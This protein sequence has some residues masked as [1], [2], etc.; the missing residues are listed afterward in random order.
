MAG[1]VA[2]MGERGYGRRDLL[3]NLKEGDHWESPGMDGRIIRQQI[4]NKYE[5]LRKSTITRS[6][7]M[8]VRRFL[9]VEQLGFHWTDFHKILYLIIL[10]KP[11][12]ENQI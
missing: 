5:K 9:R 7:V 1:L 2:L 11:V 10:R 6:F 4:L 3:G 12:E 8:P